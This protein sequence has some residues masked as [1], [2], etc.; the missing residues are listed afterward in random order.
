MKN[1]KSYVCDFIVETIL[2]LLVGDIIGVFVVYALFT[3]KLTAFAVV[4]TVNL[5]KDNR[6]IIIAVLRQITHLFFIRIGNCFLDIGLKL[7]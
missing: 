4:Y 3:Y 5:V 6:K 7:A 1:I 2:L